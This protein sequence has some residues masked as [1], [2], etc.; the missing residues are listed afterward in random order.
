MTENTLQTAVVITQNDNDK[1]IRK[2]RSSL[3]ICG[4]S[5]IALGLWAVIKT[6]FNMVMNPLNID[7][8]PELKPF[9]GLLNVFMFSVSAVILTIELGLRVFVGLSA[10]FESRG[11]TRK[12]VYIAL[13]VIIAGFIAYNVL[14]TIISML[15]MRK[16]LFTTIASLLLDISSFAVLAE[17]ISSSIRLKIALRRDKKEKRKTK[18]LTTEQK[19]G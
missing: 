14:P 5:V 2:Y 16:F 1:K 6:V 7:S 8:I 19:A 15:R 4:I 13:A 9:A 18:R 17:L 3:S 10:I 11:K 12:P